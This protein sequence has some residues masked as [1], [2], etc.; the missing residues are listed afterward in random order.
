MVITTDLLKNI[1]WKSPHSLRAARAK[2]QS[3]S[4]KQR[5]SRSDSK[6]LNVIWG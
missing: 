3:V 5:M 6:H 1:L 4:S 2:Q